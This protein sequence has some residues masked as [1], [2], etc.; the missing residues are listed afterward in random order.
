MDKVIEIKNPWLRSAGWDGFWMLSGIWLLIPLLLCANRP[1]AL[2]VMLI[3]GTAL[4]WLSHRFATTY[5][6][7][8]TP[9]YRDLVRM[10]R[11]RFIVW[12]IIVALLTFAFM[13]APNNLIQLDTWGKIQILGTIFFLYNSYHFGVQHYGVLSI[14]RIRSGQGHGGWLKGYERFY[15]IAVGAILVAIAQMCQGAQVV[16]CKH[17]S[18]CQQSND[19]RPYNKANTFQI[20]RAHV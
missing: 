13:F 8:C 14:Y 17:K 16:R 15:C 9:A 2:Q 7:F 1:G 6:A 19:D 10:E 11:V 3:V 20:G 5:T 4:F 18:K 12:P